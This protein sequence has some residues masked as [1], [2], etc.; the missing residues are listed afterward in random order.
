MMFDPPVTSTGA[1]STER[2][3]TLGQS[4]A[5]EASLHATK[6]RH[7]SSA[8]ALSLSGTQ[9]QRWRLRVNDTRLPAACREIRFT[10]VWGYRE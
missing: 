2:D 6:C 9:A 1:H 3:D 5:A 4:F 10:I 8:A 7:G